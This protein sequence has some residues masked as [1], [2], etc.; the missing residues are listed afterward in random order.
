MSEPA[1]RK[2]LLRRILTADDNLNRL[3]LVS[4]AI[5][6]AMVALNPDSFLTRNFV[7]PT[8]SRS[9]VSSPSDSPSA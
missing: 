6:A 3:I 4:V 7:C 9:W 8:P 5:F 1:P 2:P